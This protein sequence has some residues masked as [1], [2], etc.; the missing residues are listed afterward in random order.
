MEDIFQILVFV[1]I[2]VIGVAKSFANKKE[3]QK[4][5]PL[6]EDVLSDMFPEMAE[7]EQPVLQEA[8][9]HKPKP[10]RK[11]HYT[12]TMNAVSSAPTPSVKAASDESKKPE[13]PSV[14][15]SN[16]E[17]ARRAFIYSE[18]FNRKY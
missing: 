9:V 14:R 15:L 7:E 18:I 5:A 11:K 6:P 8:P 16:R 1:V 3:S 4:E 17:E 2:A 12:P 10:L 13:H